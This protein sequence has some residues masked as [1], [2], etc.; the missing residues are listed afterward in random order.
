[1]PRITY[2][3]R[4]LVPISSPPIENGRL[5]VKDGRIVSVERASGIDP[6]A[7]DLGDVAV[8]PGF[9]NAHT[10]LELT[11]CRQR[12]P[13][14]GSFV[15]WVE[16][17]VALY[18]GDRS[19][20][21]LCAS[22]REGLRQSLAAGVTTLG[23]IGYGA[24]SVDTWRRAPANVVGYL[25]V[26][27][28]GPR[29]AEPHRQSFEL[30]KAVCDEANERDPEA[31]RAPPTGGSH[32]ARGRSGSLCRVGL[33][34]HAPYSVDT[35]VYRRI[36]EYVTA[37]RRPI[38]THLAETPEETQFLADGTG[39][40]RELLERWGLWDGS[41]EPPGCSPIEYASR[42]GLLACR[43]LLIH[44][45]YVRDDDLDRLSASTCPVVY[46]PRSHRFFQ[47]E[48]HRFRDMLD[49]GIRVCIGTD[50]LASTDSL[51]VLDEL[52]FLRAEDGTIRNE[53]LLRMGTIA[54]ARALG[55][56]AQVG[57]LEPGKRADLAVLPLS[58]PGTSEPAEDVLRGQA[59]PT[60]VYLGGEPAPIGA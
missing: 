13:Y 26:L 28:M 22:V 14:A 38:C 24:R 50:S 59:L 6:R 16:D 1:M 8:V 49:R 44:V 48:P 56:D 39:P 36:I 40:F 33:S 21:S 2:R 27:G 12:V 20:D 29:R 19:E 9:V 5:V 15:R 7:V 46:C 43:P 32:S 41:F 11:Y 30:L 52:R 17:L 25:E 51:S 37:A 54:G 31:V 58:E 60:A 23:D 3:A 42:L 47:H 10:H 53:R 4:W 45:N 35:A 55:L 18:P 34:P 57:S